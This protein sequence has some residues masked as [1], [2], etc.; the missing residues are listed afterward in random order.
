MSTK[1]AEKT[2]HV[3]LQT[4]LASKLKAFTKAPRCSKSFITWQIAEVKSGIE[5]ADNSEFATEADMSA[6]YSKYAD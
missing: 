1:T 5:E 4:E 6:I 3:R 2:L